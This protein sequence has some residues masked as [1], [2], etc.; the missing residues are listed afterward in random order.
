M[1]EAEGILVVSDSVTFN[2]LKT[3]VGMCLL[4]S[5]KWFRFFETSSDVLMLNYCVIT[6]DSRPL[7]REGVINSL[8]QYDDKRTFL[9]RGKCVQN[10][11]T[12]EVSLNAASH[13]SMQDI[14]GQPTENLTTFY[15]AS[16]IIS[17][18]RP[19]KLF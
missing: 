7:N 14:K 2:Y 11:C 12:G 3:K 16:H 18:I 15:L 4:L 8:L 6:S 17:I 13:K 5:G 19:N 10:I 1:Q 9:L